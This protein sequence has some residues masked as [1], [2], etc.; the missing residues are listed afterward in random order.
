[1]SEVPVP[2]ARFLPRD[3]I[4][5]TIIDGSPCEEATC[6]KTSVERGFTPDVFTLADAKTEDEAALRWADFAVAYRD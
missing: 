5:G 3:M 6:H 1:M 4:A 2:E